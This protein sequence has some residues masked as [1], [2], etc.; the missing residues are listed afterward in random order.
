MYYFV[1]IDMLELYAI[2]ARL[3]SG[4]GK[5]GAPLPVILVTGTYL[6]YHHDLAWTELPAIDVKRVVVH[7]IL[8][9]RFVLFLST[10]NFVYYRIMAIDSNRGE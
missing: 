1:R 6:G 8:F 5:L 10:F 2:R 7:E 3:D 9:H 4:R